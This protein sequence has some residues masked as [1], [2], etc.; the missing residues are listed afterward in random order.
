MA[1]RYGQDRLARLEQFV[2]L[3]IAENAHQN[4]ISQASLA[5]VWVR[6]ILDSAQL[7]RL[8]GGANRWL[9]V[10]SGPG[11][12]GM[13]LACLSDTPILMV[14]PRRRRVEFLERAISE[15]RLA[16][17]EVRQANVERLSDQR[18]DAVTARA[19]APLTEIFRSTVQ[20]TTSS[21]IWVLPKGRSAERELDEARQ[22]WQGVFHVEQSLTDPDARIIVARDVSP[23]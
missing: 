23:R 5:G 13:V 8:A 16:H 17:A 14:E 3:L 4:L 2:A 9:D 15:L 22:T 21:T 7:H 1:E 18:F 11:L 20:L 19:Y 12:P 6:H 10:G